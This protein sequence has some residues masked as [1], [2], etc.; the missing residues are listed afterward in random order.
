MKQTIRISAEEVA[1][2]LKKEVIRRR[3]EL[4]GKDF[5]V[6]RQIKHYGFEITDPPEPKKKESGESGFIVGKIVKKK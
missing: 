4:E 2:I 1:E 3:P 5:K 6:L